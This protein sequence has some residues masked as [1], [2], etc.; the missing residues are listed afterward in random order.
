MSFHCISRK[1]KLHGNNIGNRQL[2]VSINAK[3][4]KT[5]KWVMID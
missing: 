4:M 2:T 5:I 3:L 1:R